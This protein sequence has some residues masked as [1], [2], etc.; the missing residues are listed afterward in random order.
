METVNWEEAMSFCREL[1]RRAREAGIELP[2]GY[3]FTLPTEA[4]W[5]YAARG[6]HRK[7]GYHVYSGGNNLD[8]VGWYDDNSGDRTHPVGT[9]SPNELGIYDMS[10]NVYEWCRD[11]YGGYGNGTAT[12][13]YCKS[14]SL[15]VYR[16]GGWLSNA[17]SCRVAD[18]NG[19]A[20]SDRG[21][22]LG[23]RVALAPV[24]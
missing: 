4:Q 19:G 3:E 6:G 23:F 14:G 7:S 21:G 20:P 9:K 5:E 2:D 24:Q 15:R 11:Y 13:P 16:G 8:A 22:D 1:T 12:A 17:R 18:R 10:G